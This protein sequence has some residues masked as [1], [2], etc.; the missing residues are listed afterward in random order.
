MLYR[1]S[2][3][4]AT[5]RRASRPSNG[6]PRGLGKIAAATRSNSTK[7]SMSAAIRGRR[8]SKY[9]PNRQ[10]RISLPK[11]SDAPSPKSCTLGR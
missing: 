7:E 3:R 2:G 8:A 1:R 11:L 4:S 10:T 6:P 5:L 9:L